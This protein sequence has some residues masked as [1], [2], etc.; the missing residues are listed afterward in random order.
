MMVACIIS[1]FA[2]LTLGI[3]ANIK[4]YDDE[5]GGSS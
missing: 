4:V 3:I 1:G 5:R 2:A